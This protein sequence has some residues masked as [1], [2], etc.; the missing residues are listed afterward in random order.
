MLLSPVQQIKIDKE[1]Y[2]Y[3]SHLII[4][5]KATNFTEYLQRFE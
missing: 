2:W 3:L 4:T 5:L 1:L